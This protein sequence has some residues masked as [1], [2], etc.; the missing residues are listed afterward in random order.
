MTEV[1][2]I[3]IHQH[4]YAI[5]NCTYDRLRLGFTASSPSCWQLLS[6]RLIPTSILRQVGGQVSDQVSGQKLHESGR[7]RGDSRN[8]E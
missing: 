7:S 5:P 1:N 3:S 8:H 6:D 2:T 4:H